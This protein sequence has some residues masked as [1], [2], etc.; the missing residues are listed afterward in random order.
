MVTH[1]HVK[2]E[3]F[4]NITQNIIYTCKAQFCIRRNLNLWFLDRLRWQYFPL[5]AGF[6]LKI[7][8]PSLGM[9]IDLQIRKK[10]KRRHWFFRFWDVILV[11]SGD[12]TVCKLTQLAVVLHCSRCR[13]AHGKHNY[14]FWQPAHLLPVRSSDRQENNPR[15]RWNNGQLKRGASSCDL[16]RVS[17]LPQRNTLGVFS[18]LWNNSS[19]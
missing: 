2:H 16:G 7:S 14:K 4:E 5:N 11:W 18:I 10:K 9:P 12:Y 1:E 15:T 8:I 19:Q 3:T 6:S 13:V 17:F